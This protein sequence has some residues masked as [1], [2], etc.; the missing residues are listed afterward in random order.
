MILVFF[1]VIGFLAGFLVAATAF[2]LKF[3]RIL[4]V[5]LAQIDA[6]RPTALP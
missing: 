1:T 4:D 5:L 3:N 6:D 2:T